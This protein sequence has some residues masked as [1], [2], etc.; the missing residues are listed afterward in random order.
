MLYDNWYLLPLDI[1]WHEKSGE[2]AINQWSGD[3][4]NIFNI[5]NICPWV[6]QEWVRNDL[7]ACLHLRRSSP[8]ETESCLSWWWKDKLKMR[9]EKGHGYVREENVG[10]LLQTFWLCKVQCLNQS[11]IILDYFYFLSN[12]SLSTCVWSITLSM[13]RWNKLECIGKATKKIK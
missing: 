6:I 13:I 4:L 11:Q 2:G 5:W 7:P 9:G 12:H 10:W 1:I 3:T 8:R